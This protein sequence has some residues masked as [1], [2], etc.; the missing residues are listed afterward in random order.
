MS[1]KEQE[2]IILIQKILDG[3]QI[4]QITLYEKYKKFVKNFI[5]NKYS[6][7]YDL[8]DDVSEIMIRIFLNLKE[9]NQTKSKFRSWVICIAKNYMIDKWRCGTIIINSLDRPITLTASFDNVFTVS[10]GSS[11]QHAVSANNNSGELFDCNCSITASNNSAFVANSYFT[12]SNAV[13]FEN[14]NSLNHISNQLSPV[15]YTLLDMKY[16][17]GYEYC[18]IGKEFNISSNTVS[19]RVNYLKTKLKKNNSELIYE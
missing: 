18:E 10:N 11:G 12:I 8:D 9:Y 7:I 6:I 14:C 15:D 2:D 19:N 4:A 13:N 5:R 1:I 3:N 16:A 17:Q